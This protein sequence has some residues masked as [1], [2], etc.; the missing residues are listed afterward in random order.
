MT[1]YAIAQQTGISEAVL[2]RFA[3]GLTGLSMENFNRLCDLFGLELRQTR[4][5]KAKE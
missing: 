2:S 3:N 1:R 5:R 4:R